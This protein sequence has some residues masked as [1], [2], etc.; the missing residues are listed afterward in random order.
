MFV[1]QRLVPAETKYASQF[2]EQLKAATNTMQAIGGD[3][4][5]TAQRKRSGISA[6][7]GMGMLP[8]RELQSGQVLIG[9]RAKPPTHPVPYLPTY[10]PT[11]LQPT[12][13]VQPAF[14]SSKKSGGQ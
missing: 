13:Y 4:Y 8:R 14:Y 5:R 1:V 12:T 10:P 3:Q 6:H 11:Y 7:P 2:I 9:H